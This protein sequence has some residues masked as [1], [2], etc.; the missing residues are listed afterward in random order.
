MSIEK[1]RLKMLVAE[2]LGR[3]L[4]AARDKA[5]RDIY[6]HQGAT[7]ALNKAEEKLNQVTQNLK[8]RF[9]KSDEPFPFDPE[10]RIE[11]GKFVVEQ[12]MKGSAAIH[13]LAD[14][15]SKSALRAEGIKLGYDE[16]VKTVFKVFDQEKNELVGLAEAIE[17][18]RVRQDG[19]NLVLAQNEEDPRAP[20]PVGTHPGLPLKSRRNAGK[21]APTKKTTKPRKKAS[22]KDA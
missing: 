12:I 10:N 21:K 5:A 6:R 17:A 22:A 14:V 15:A 13:E 2:N 7:T 16:S 11:V 1:S 19:D 20:K 18:D 4:E 3:E 8:D 9:I